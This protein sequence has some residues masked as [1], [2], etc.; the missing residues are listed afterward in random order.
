M[1][2][3]QMLPCKKHIMINYHHL[4]IFVVN[5]DVEIKHVDTKEHIADIFTKLLDS[6]LFGYICC[7]LN[8]W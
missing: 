8:S 3:L 2:S 7:K 1:V 5:G 6:E 4:Q